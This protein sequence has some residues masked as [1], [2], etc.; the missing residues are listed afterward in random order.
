MK[1]CLVIDD[2]EV[3][4][5]TS[6]Q[7]LKALGMVPVAVATFDEALAELRKSTFEVVLLDWHLRKISGLDLIANVKA[8]GGGKV[9]VFSGVEGL[10]KKD[11][12]LRA[13]ADAF[14]EKPTTKEKLEACFKDVGII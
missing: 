10:E 3:T 4:R 9:I 11:E 5:F 12:A 1:K 6:E 7:I 13:G 2:V 14:L 8:A